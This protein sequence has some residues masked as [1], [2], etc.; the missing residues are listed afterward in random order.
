VV[1]RYLQVVS[2]AEARRILAT[3]M[4]ATRKTEIVPLEEA[5]GRVTAGPIMA[6]Y[7]VPQIHLSAMDG[8]AVKSADTVKASEQHPVML[9]DALRVNTGNVVPPTYDAV[10]MIEDVWIEG[11]T[12][13]IR[14]AAAPWQHIR[15]AGEEISETEMILPAAHRIIPTDL[16]ALAGYGMTG[17]EVL[18]LKVGLIPTGSEVIEH[19]QRPKPGQ[20]V[21]SNCFFA[22]GWL[23][24]IGVA[25]HLYPITIDDQ[26]LIRA[27]ITRGVAENDLLIISA[28]SSAGTKDFTAGV[29]GELGEVLVHGVAIKPGKPVIIGRIQGKPVIGLPGYP[30]S[31]LTV[32]R[33]L[34][35]PALQEYGLQPPE[36]PTIR[37]SITRTVQKEIGSDEFVLVSAGEIDGR[38]VAVPQSRGAGVQMSMVRSNGYLQLAADQEGVVAGEEVQ[39]QLTVPE[40]L[41]KRALLIIGSHDP[42]IDHLASLVSGE[43]VIIH[44]THVGSMGGLLTLRQHQCHAA[45][46]HLL[47]PDGTYNTS[48]LQQYLPDDDLVLLCVAEREQGFVSTTGL[49]VE[50]IQKYTFVNRQQGSGTRMLL[51]H[52]LREHQIDP[53]SIRGYDHEVTTHL[54]VAVAV[55]SGEADLGLCVYSAAAALGLKFVPLATERYELAIERRM[56]D[57]PRVQKLIGAVRSPAFLHILER[58]GGYR[59]AETGVLREVP[60]PQPLPDSHT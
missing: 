43:G 24:S 3:L 17:V 54:A 40:A 4:P 50:D 59:T 1:T 29:I 26:D 36:Y 5:V 13:T 11:E 41:G 21:E 39:V 58:M 37:A 44:S 51:D 30:L 15:P 27:A 22:A 57:D 31:A 7:S 23:R 25:T 14:K 45:P 16:G 12:Y 49:S 19:G 34:V 52:Y 38:W 47:A 35:I 6:A 46:M 60:R 2:L 42:A 53:A 28:G 48:Y 8:I 18:G 55:R 32:M 10:I 33:E 56:L 9:P 20:V